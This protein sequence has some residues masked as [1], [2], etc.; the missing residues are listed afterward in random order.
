M[1]RSGRS[2]VPSVEPRM[3]MFERGGALDLTELAP[4]AYVTPRHS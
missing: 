2:F 1:P 4:S 3:M